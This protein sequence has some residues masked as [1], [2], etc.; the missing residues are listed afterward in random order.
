MTE[1]T[2]NFKAENPI[3]V[4]VYETPTALAEA[5]AGLLLES[6][7][8]YPGEIITVAV[9]GGN[10]PKSIFAH[11]ASTFQTEIA[12]ERI[13]FFWV[14]ER[15]VAP[16]DQQSN[17]KMTRETLLQKVNIPGKQIFPIFVDR[18][19]A[20]DAQRYARVLCQ[21]VPLAN[22]LPRFHLIFLGMG[23]DGHTASIFPG[24]GHLFTTRECCATSVHPVTGQQRVTLTGAVLNNACQVAFL[25]TGSS[26]SALIQ[27]ILTALKSDRACPISGNIPP[28][29]IPLPSRKRQHKQ[30]P[31]FPAARVRPVSGTI[32]WL[33]DREAFSKLTGIHTKFSVETS[34]EV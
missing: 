7:R 14:D 25:V 24:Q 8:A 9:S 13:K 2:A 6:L 31:E 5:A 3:S 10:T 26:K 30:P 27:Q 34:G 32:C 21:N 28:G 20:S 29:R 18:E 22:G 12:W 16:D 4:A 33:L 11:W 17:Y 15:C 23:E 19:P 1:Y